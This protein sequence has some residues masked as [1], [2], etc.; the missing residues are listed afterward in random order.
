MTASTSVFR[1]RSEFDDFLFAPIDDDGNGMLSVLSALT[2]LDFDPWQEAAD[3]ARLS[4]D[5][6]TRRLA[7]LIASLPD[8]LS[9]PRDVARIAARLVA[10]LPR[11]APIIIPIPARATL[12]DGAS[13]E[14]LRG[15]RTMLFAI[16]IALVLGLLWIASR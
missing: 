15:N 2:Q 7:G 14:F 9:P 10:L 16:L 5:K 11:G 1:V 8:P 12:R 13:L 4:V 3:L 6:A